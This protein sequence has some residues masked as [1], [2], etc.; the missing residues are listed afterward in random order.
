MLD[1]S[2]QLIGLFMPYL[3]QSK[4]RPK[5]LLF[6]L[7]SSG[8]VLQWIDLDLLNEA[9]KFDCSALSLEYF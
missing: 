5:L 7:V 9:H 2:F 6:H 4:L 3:L 8:L 1:G